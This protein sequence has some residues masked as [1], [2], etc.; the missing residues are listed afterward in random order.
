MYLSKPTKRILNWGL[1][2]V[3][4]VLMGDGANRSLSN[5]QTYSDSELEA[6]SKASENGEAIVLRHKKDAAV[7][8]VL[9]I[10]GGSIVL[11]LDAF[12]LKG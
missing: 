12:V 11:G 4:V 2:A 5:P 7:V 8:G 6:I 10:I 3:A 9:E 1:A